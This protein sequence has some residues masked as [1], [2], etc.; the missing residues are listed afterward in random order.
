MTVSMNACFEGPGSLR[1]GTIGLTLALF[2]SSATPRR[3][4]RR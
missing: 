4:V 2:V 1:A 3:V